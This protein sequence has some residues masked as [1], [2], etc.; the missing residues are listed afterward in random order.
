MEIITFSFQQGFNEFFAATFFLTVE[1]SN[2][3][4]EEKQPDSDKG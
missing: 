1:R 4:G 2:F 3:Y